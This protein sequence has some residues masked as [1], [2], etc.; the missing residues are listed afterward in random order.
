MNI[1]CLLWEPREDSG[2]SK[3]KKG[4]QEMRVE[5]M[6]EFPIKKKRKKEEIEDPNE[7]YIES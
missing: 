1:V 7:A 3:M 6:Y 4:L 5:W 2:S